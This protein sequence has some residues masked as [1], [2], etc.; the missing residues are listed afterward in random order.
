MAVFH[1]AHD[2]P[3]NIASAYNTTCCN[4]AGFVKGKVS[5][6]SYAVKIPPKIF[7]FISDI[8]NTDQSPYMTKIS[9]LHCD[10]LL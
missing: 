8:N 3:R 7:S 1:S 2:T 6:V 4:S 9:S 5:V 10:I